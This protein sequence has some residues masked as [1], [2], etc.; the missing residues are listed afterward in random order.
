MK[1]NTINPCYIIT[2]ILLF[3]VSAC[4]KETKKEISDL[5]K[6]RKNNN[7]KTYTVT[8]LDSIRSINF[9]TRQK[10]QEVL[11]LS[12]L[13]LDGNRN[14]KID[15]AI[16]K[17][18]QSYFDS[19]DSTVLHPLFDELESLKVKKVKVEQL[20]VFKKI[21][22]KDSVKDTT[23]YARFNVEYFDNKNNSLG[24]FDRYA[25]YTLKSH[26]V[27]YKKEFKFYFKNIYLSPEKDSTSVGVIK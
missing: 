26:P 13:Y 24:K 22:T 20:E 27:K 4:K 9:I 2:A 19:K 14:T 11:D 18:I 5:N 1:K 8:T 23:N 10:I 7:T 3:F 21:K 6:L 25:E 16:Y 15:S 17:Q 12:S